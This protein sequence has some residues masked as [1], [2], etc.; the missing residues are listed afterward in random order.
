LR[1]SF[2]EEV[3]SDGTAILGIIGGLLGIIAAFLAI[4]VV[5]EIQ[6]QQVESSKLIPNQPPAFASPPA[7]PEFN[8]PGNIGTPSTF[9]P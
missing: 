5:R 4:K 8:Q 3:A 2:R 6:R 7:P 1:I 9:N